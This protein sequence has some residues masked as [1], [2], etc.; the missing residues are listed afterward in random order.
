MR[1]AVSQI[2][3][4]SQRIFRRLLIVSQSIQRRAVDSAGFHDLRL[5]YL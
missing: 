3:N 4:G 1:Y 2:L 5:L